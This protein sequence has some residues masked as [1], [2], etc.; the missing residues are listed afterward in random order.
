LTI[1]VWSDVL[2]RALLGALADEEIASEWGVNLSN[3]SGPLRDELCAWARDDPEV[4]KWIA[5]AWRDRNEPVVEETE[6]YAP[7]ELAERVE[8]LCEQFGPEL[9][10]LALVTDEAARGTD[11]AD[12]FVQHIASAKRRQMVWAALHRLLGAPAEAP[13]ALKRVV[14]FGGHPRDEANLDEPLSNLGP[15]EIRWETFERTSGGGAADAR[16]ITAALS[17]RTPPSSCSAW[18]AMPWPASSDLRRRRTASRA[19]PSTEPPAGN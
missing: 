7:E 9:L 8:A 12:N 19:A 17:A 16:S 18:R 14:V 1:N 2:A 3:G 5:A 15:F 11:L 6:S 4:R 13:Q 10:L